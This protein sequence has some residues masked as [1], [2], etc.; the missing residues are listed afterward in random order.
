MQKLSRAFQNWRPR[1]PQ[2]VLATIAAAGLLSTSFLLQGSA[3]VHAPGDLTWPLVGVLHHQLTEAASSPAEEQSPEALLGRARQLRIN[4]A[5]E[6]STSLYRSAL[7][8]GAANPGAAALGAAEAS[9]AAGDYRGTIDLAQQALRAT[10]PATDA[11]VVQAEA[12][13]ALGDGEQAIE[14]IRLHVAGNPG[15]GYSAFRAAEMRAAQG[16]YAAA[17]FWYEQ[18]IDLGLSRT[19]A[20]VAAARLGRSFWNIDENELAVTWLQRASTYAAQGAELGTPTWFDAELARLLPETRR[21]AILLDLARAQLEVEQVDAAIDTFARI[22]AISPSSSE[23]SVALARLADLFAL[24]RV[25]AYQRGL[26]YLNHDRYDDAVTAFERYLDAFPTGADAAGATY[27]HADAHWSQGQYG[28]ARVEFEQMAAAFP[29]SPLAPE[30]LWSSARVAERRGGRAEA[31]A[32]YHSVADVFPNSQQAAR[33]LLRLGWMQLGDGDGDGARA[34]WERLG[35]QH[36]D[37]QWR[38]EGLFALGR[39][40]LGLGNT[41]AGRGAL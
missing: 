33:A 1:L 22:P 37:P 13:W 29:S 14:V 25:S 3:T 5:Y 41:T 10:P 8:R 12:Y 40:L 23:A 4:G 17:R 39:G 38:A 30:A 26:V 32:A 16:N 28:L 36:P 18:A 7:G 24:D 2:R 20:T 27:Y 31:K 9:L 15:S 19:W 34:S 21:V 35:R 6:E 11:Y